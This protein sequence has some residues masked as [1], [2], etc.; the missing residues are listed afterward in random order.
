VLDLLNDDL[1]KL[2]AAAHTTD[3][4]GGSGFGLYGAASKN[5][6]DDE[7]RKAKENVRRVKGVLLS[8]RSFPGGGR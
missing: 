3:F 6:P 1:D 5:E 7:I 2:D 4:V 8:T